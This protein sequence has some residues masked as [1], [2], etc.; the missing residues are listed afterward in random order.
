MIGS[1]YRRIH[2]FL[3]L[4]LGPR[5]IRASVRSKH[6]LEIRVHPEDKGLD[7]LSPRLELA[8]RRRQCGCA[9]HPRFTFSRADYIAP[10]LHSQYQ[11]AADPLLSHLV[12]A[13]VRLVVA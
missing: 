8:R 4:N 11:V 7:E 13:Y 3:F 1:R 12:P 10:D 2:D 5:N 9:H 6:G